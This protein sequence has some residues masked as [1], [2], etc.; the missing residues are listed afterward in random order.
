MI[1]MRP[2]L[3]I[4]LLLAACATSVAEVLAA[5]ARTAM[6]RAA[7]YYHSNVAVHGGYVYHTSENLSVR[8]GEGLAGDD[9]IW[10]QPPGTPTVGIAFLK[11]YEATG[12]RFF[13]QA[14]HDAAKAMAFGQL[15]G[16][17]WTNSIDLALREEGYPFSGGNKRREGNC[18]L[19]DG[20]TQTAIIFM[21]LMDE[22]LD[23]KDEQV[24]ESAT[25]ALDS[26]LAAQFPNGAFPQ[27]WRGAVEE[28]AVLKASYHQYDWRT[29]GRVKNYWDYY[30][31]KAN[32]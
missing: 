30:T 4:V 1:L 2:L 18:S 24:H 3:L 27:V 12:N 22:A 31:L 23:F 8:W 28:Q 29:A 26:L 32:V 9:Q 17:G 14:A 6:R 7:G 16:G 13:L 15:R 21:A 25:L 10:V 19:D 20:Q 11:A 5:D